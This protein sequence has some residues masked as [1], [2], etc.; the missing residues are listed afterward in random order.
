MITTLRTDSKNTDFIDLV[1]ALDAYLKTTDGDEHEFYNQYNNIDVLDHV[2]VAYQNGIAVGCG[3]F[4]TF[5]K[6]SVEIKRMYTKPETRGLG[7]ATTILNALE[8]W[9]SELNY[10]TCI[11]ETGKRQIEAVQFYK[12]NNYSIIPNYGQY[13]HMANSLCFEKLI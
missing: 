6:S 2:I 11:L 13:K 3:A 9:A 8:S 7:I 12:K 5:D 10:S 1:E 4:K